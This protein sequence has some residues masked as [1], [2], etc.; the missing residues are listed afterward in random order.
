MIQL[1]YTLLVLV[2]IYQIFVSFLI[3]R[4]EE[5]ERAQRLAQITLIW[6]IPIMTAFVLHSF[7]RNQR[8]TSHVKINN[9]SAQD[10]NVILGYGD[11]KD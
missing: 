1:S 9:V 6:F 2:I 8:K 5:Y 4:A 3:Y 10:Q 11:I 7:L